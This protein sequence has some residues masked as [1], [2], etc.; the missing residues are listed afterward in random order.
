MRRAPRSMIRAF[1]VAAVAGVGLAATGIAS[2]A[3]FGGP[4]AHVVAGPGDLWWNKA[5]AAVASPA[6]LGWTHNPLALSVK[7]ADRA[8]TTAVPNCTGSVSPADLGWTHNALGLS[9]KPADLGWTTAARSAGRVVPV[10]LG[11][12]HAARISTV[13]PAD[14]GWTTARPVSQPAGSCSSQGDQ[15]A[16][17][18]SLM[19]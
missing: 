11:W 12:T 8:W 19:V 2:A 14:L 3:V 1:V 15:V 10:D 9:T 6:D 17:A 4:V 18:S 16:E 7:P 5:G 13:A